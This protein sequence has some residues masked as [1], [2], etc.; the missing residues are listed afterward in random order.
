MQHL[1]IKTLLASAALW[2]SPLAN[3]YVEGTGLFLEPGVSYQHVSSNINYGGTVAAN[4]SATARG[5]GVIG[6]AGVHVYE[7]FFVA[8]DA[9]YAFPCFEDNANG[10]SASAQSWDIAPVIGMQMPDWGA[11]VF[12]GYVL[13]GALDPQSA[14][15]ANVK[16]ENPN[17]WRAGFGLKLKQFSVNIEWQHLHYGKA[18][19]EPAAG[20]NVTGVDYNAEGLVASITFPIGFE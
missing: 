16:F 9:R 20:G 15:N 7:S 13:A 12:V 19:V 18:N 6:R 1:T 2:L 5:F 17:G 10:Y 3:A 14:N 11:R 4:S 8:A